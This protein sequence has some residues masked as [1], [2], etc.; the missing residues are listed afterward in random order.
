[1]HGQNT[2]RYSSRVHAAKESINKLNN[3]GSKVK[4]WSIL[5]ESSYKAD[6][7]NVPHLTFYE[8]IFEYT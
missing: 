5:P 2:F 8:Y 1:M 7:E 6:S 4:I 3:N